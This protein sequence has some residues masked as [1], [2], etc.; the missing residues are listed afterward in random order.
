MVKDLRPDILNLVPDP[1]NYDPWE[2]ED[3]PSFPMVDDELATTNTTGDYLI[4]SN[5][6]LPVGNSQ[7]LARV[8][9]WK[10]DVTGALIGTVH[11][12]PALDTCVYEVHFP[13][14]RSKE[15]AANVMAEA[16]YAQCD[17]NGN[18]YVLLDSIVDYQCNGDVAVSCNNQVKVVDGKKMVA[19]FTRGWELCCAWKDGSTS[20]Q[21]LSDLK[22]LL[23]LQV[24][25]F[26][27][28]AGIADEPAFNW[29]VSWVLKKRDRIVSLVKH[30]SARYHNCTHKFGVEHS[31]SIDEAYAI[32]AATGTSFWCVMP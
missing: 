3:R 32:D 2:D 17:V 30:R 16:L 6:L 1:T 20:W 27:L 21:K 29:W 28:P 5:V 24:A 18:D 15:L 22:E 19:C 12:Q 13:D 9:C 8:V 31:K 25:E 7:E 23:P 4:Y 14:S 26:V 11:K 10:R